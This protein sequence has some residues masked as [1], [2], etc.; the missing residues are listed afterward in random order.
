[1]PNKKYEW[2]GFHDVPMARCNKTGSRRCFSKFRN[3]EES[4]KLIKRMLGYNIELSELTTLR[5]G[6]PTRF[7]SGMKASI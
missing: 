4:E 3:K 2:C 6:N 7:S 5:A 1:M